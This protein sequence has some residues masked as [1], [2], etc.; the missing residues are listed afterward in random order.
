MKNAFLQG[1]L[2]EHVFIY[3]N[4]P[5]FVRAEQVDSWPV[6]EVTLPPQASPTCFKLE[7]TQY[8]RKMGFTV[9][10]FD[11]S[12][13]IQKGPNGPVCILLYVDDLV[14]TLPGFDEIGCVKSQLSDAFGSR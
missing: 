4:P 9:S 11:S 3:S 5:N 10:K 14:I 2:E 6:E 7:K 1:N 12:L 13:F 8:L